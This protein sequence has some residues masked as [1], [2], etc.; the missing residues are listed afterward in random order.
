MSLPTITRRLSTIVKT[1]VSYDMGNAQM[2]IVENLLT[3]CQLGRTM[4]FK[5]APPL[6]S[7]FVTPE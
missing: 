5:T 7:F 1:V 3:A 4:Q 2:I 6:D